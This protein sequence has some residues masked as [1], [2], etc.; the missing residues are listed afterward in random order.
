M[1]GKKEIHEDYKISQYKRYG[2]Y[3]IKMRRYNL[4]PLPFYKW[5]EDYREKE[6]LN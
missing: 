2:G 4:E 3:C 6:E 1:I 5:K